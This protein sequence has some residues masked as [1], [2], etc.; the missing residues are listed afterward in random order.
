MSWVV[1][2]DCSFAYWCVS[3]GERVISQWQHV[4]AILS[5]VDH[6]EKIQLVGEIIGGSEKTG[7][8]T[9]VFDDDKRHNNNNTYTHACLIAT[10]YCRKTCSCVLQVQLHH[11]NNK[12]VIGD[13]ENSF[14][15]EIDCCY[16]PQ[17]FANK[18]TY[19]WQNVFG[20]N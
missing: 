17:I 7:K 18:H 4:H 11:L 5:F 20:E 15:I 16:L 19:K 9:S 6:R 12:K 10:C 14:W 8:R 1:N 2:L 13:Q 3:E